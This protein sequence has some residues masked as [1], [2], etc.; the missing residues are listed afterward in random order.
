MTTKISFTKDMRTARKV[1]R[2]VECG[3]RLLSDEH[4]RCSECEAYRDQ[5][6]RSP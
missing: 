1:R 6:R 4:R 5:T 3:T 2:C